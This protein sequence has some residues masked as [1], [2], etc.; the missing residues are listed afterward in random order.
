M[1]LT[2]LWIGSCEKLQ[3]KAIGDLNGDHFPADGD[4]PLGG[5][6]FFNH[7]LSAAYIP[8]LAP[9]LKCDSKWGRLQIVHV[10]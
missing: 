8:H 6:P 9:H 2:A 5:D 4:F 1:R 7:D 3:D 10:Q